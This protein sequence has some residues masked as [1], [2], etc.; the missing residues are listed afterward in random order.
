MSCSWKIGSPD[1]GQLLVELLM[2]PS[3]LSMWGLS[4]TRLSG[5]VRPHWHSQ[6]T[7]ARRYHRCSFLPNCTHRK[8]RPCPPDFSPATQHVAQWTLLSQERECSFCMRWL[9]STGLSSAA[10][11]HN[12]SRPRDVALH[13]HHRHRQ[14]G[15]RPQRPLYPRHNFNIWCYQYV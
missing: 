10:G 3:S 2:L 12:S 11:Q 13:H 7:V 15:C 4:F 14:N 1:K 9:H 6:H 8:L 5:N